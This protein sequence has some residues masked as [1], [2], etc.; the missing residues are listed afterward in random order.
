MK[1]HYV[2]DQKFILHIH[3]GSYDQLSPKIF[4]IFSSATHGMRLSKL[5]GCER[6]ELSRRRLSLLMYLLRSPFYDKFTKWVII[7]LLT[8]AQHL[9][10]PLAGTLFDTFMSYVPHYRKLYHYIWSK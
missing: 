9:N 3:W 10:L 7:L 2:Y 8:Y 1:K 6:Q 4:S 5:H